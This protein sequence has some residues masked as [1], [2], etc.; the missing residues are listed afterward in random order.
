MIGRTIHETVTCLLV[1]FCS[2]SIVGHSTQTNLKHQAAAR[3]AAHLPCNSVRTSDINYLTIACGDRIFD[4]IDGTALNYDRPGGSG[5]P[6]WKAKFER[7]TVVEPNPGVAVRLLLI[8]DSH[9]TG[10]RWR[11]YL[12]AYRCSNGRL[13]QVVHRDGLS[14]KIDR[15]DSS[16]ITVSLNTVSGQKLLRCIGRT[17]GISSDPHMYCSQLGQRRDSPLH[18][19]KYPEPNGTWLPRR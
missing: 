7:D 2:W 12:V 11:Y 15:L 8:R 4:F 5:T 3:D 19:L 18:C 1:F 13:Q 9:E 14:L 6:D 17:F 10:R 16:T